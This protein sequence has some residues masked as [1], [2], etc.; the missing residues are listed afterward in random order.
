MTFTPDSHTPYQW[1]N[2]PSHGTP[3]DSAHLEAAETDLVQYT[4]A[5]DE[6]VVNYFEGGS[7]AF[8][9]PSSVATINSGSSAKLPVFYV[10][11]PSGDTSGATDA[12]AI[13]S[14][15]NALK[16]FANGNGILRFQ[17]GTYY[18]NSTQVYNSTVGVIWEGSGGVT[19]GASAGTVVKYVGTAARYLDARSS[20]GFKVRDIMVLATDAS[21]AGNLLDLSHDTSGNDASLWK[22]SDSHLS[23]TNTSA[24]TVIY[25]DQAISG[26]V[27]DN[28]IGGGLFGIQ[29][30]AVSGHYSNSV[31][32][33]GNTFKN[34]GP[35]DGTGAAI[36]GPGQGWDI[37]G[38]NTFELGATPAIVQAFVSQSGG[39]IS[40][41]WFGDA[42]GTQTVITVVNGMSVTG[43]YIAG[44]ANTTG[45]A[46]VAGGSGISIRGNTFASHSVGIALIGTPTGVVY[47]ANTFTSVTTKW[48]A[49]T[50][51]PGAGAGTG[52]TASLSG[53]PNDQR[54]TVLVTTGNA[55]ATGALVT[56]TFP[57]SRT[58]PRP[59]ITAA[60]AN[61]V[62]LQ[63]Y[64]SITGNTLTI[65]LPNAAPAASTT[66]VWFYNRPD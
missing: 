14:A 42:T 50:A 20:T 8:G 46:T 47:D 32:V 22:I 41:N 3:L 15:Y 28:F 59:T 55:T 36:S 45:V 44:N 58:D 21:F 57:V 48:T 54:G 5:Q 52:A 12:A 11:P 33:T 10:A 26:S 63:S 40:G 30:I 34:Q 53:T 65:N 64:V 2:A 56:V 60:N 37:S 27:R 18:D 24:G 49:P 51:A 9:P 7:S 39:R 29:G 16:L 6:K 31:A 62:A 13:L 23:I 25:L 43:N 35:G 1:Q 61:T 17:P 66:Y 19:P 4:Q 38:A